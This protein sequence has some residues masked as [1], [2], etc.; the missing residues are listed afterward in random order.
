LTSIFSIVEVPVTGRKDS[1]IPSTRI[2]IT[3]LETSKASADARKPQWR[4]S[5][6]HYQ[7]LTH[8]WFIYKHWRAC[9]KLAKETQP[10]FQK[11]DLGAVARKKRQSIVFKNHVTEKYT[12]A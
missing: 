2:K 12:T 7:S 4:T 10:S 3:F 6:F 11:K 8:R 5:L 9:G 1:Q